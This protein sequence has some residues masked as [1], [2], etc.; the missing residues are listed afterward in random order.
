MV[1]EENTPPEPQ[2][3]GASGLGGTLVQ[4]PGLI[5]QGT[6]RRIRRLNAQPQPQLINLDV[7][8]DLNIL[9]NPGC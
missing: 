3:G 1:D 9:A 8:R 6:S 4:T 2:Y 7:V 5:L